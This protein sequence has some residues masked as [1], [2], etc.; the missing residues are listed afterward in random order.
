MKV[1]VEVNRVLCNSIKLFS[2]RTE[3]EDK[4][5]PVLA[6][7]QFQNSGNFRGNVQRSESGAVPKIAESV[8]KRNARDRH[9][10]ADDRMF[11]GHHLW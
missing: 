7:V 1:L 8:P 11:T 2:I 5:V 6:G 10:P 9:L 4:E 3:M